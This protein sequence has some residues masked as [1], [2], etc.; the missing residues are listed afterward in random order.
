MRDL[1]VESAAARGVMSEQLILL[2]LRDKELIVHS[3]VSNKW[4]CPDK[5]D[6]ID[7]SLKPGVPVSRTTLNT[8]STS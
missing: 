8:T 2:D 3:S 1:L 4:K 7:K 6:K 5:G